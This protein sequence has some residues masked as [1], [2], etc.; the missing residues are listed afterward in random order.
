[1]RG[2]QYCIDAGRKSA[3]YMHGVVVGLGLA[4]SLLNSVICRNPGGEPS[5]P[6]PRLRPK[7]EGIN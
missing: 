5:S 3:Y 4:T 6:R 1:M 2:V 7:K